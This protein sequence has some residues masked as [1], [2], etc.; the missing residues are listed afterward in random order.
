MITDTR[1]FNLDGVK[2]CVTQLFIIDFVLISVFLNTRVF[3]YLNK[4]VFHHF[5]YI[6]LD[7][8]QTFRLN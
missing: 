2:T 5:E 6:I 4:I 8:S 7:Y 3:L 1:V